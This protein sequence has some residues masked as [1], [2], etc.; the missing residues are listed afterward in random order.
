MEAVRLYAQTEDISCTTFLS[1]ILTD[2]AFQ[3]FILYKINHKIF[4]FCKNKHLLWIIPKFLQYFSKLFFGSSISPEAQIGSNFRIFYG[5]GIII[6]SN[7][8]IGNNVTI[9]NGVSIGSSIPGQSLIKQPKIGDNVMIGTGAKILGDITIGNNVM[10]GANSV[11]TH[12]FDSNVSIAGAPAKI[13][14]HNKACPPDL[15]V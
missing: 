3:L 9:F 14:K 4:L 15:M 5:M 12:S 8:T 10:I 2:M 1:V 6:G 7:V 13:I 11:V